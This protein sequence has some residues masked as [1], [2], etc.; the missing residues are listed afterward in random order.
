MTE[1]PLVIY[2]PENSKIGKHT[3]NFDK[4][5]LYLNYRINS[6]GIT[7]E[8][9]P[10][11]KKKMIDYNKLIS[12]YEAETKCKVGSCPTQKKK[13]NLKAKLLS[14]EKPNQNT[15]IRDALKNLTI[16]EVYNFSETPLT[17]FEKVEK[18]PV[19]QLF[20]KNMQNQ[21]MPKENLYKFMNLDNICR[22]DSLED[23]RVFSFNVE[24]LVKER[25]TEEKHLMKKC[26]SH[27]I[28]NTQNCPRNAKNLRISKSSAVV[29]QIQ[30]KIE[31]LRK[32]NISLRRK[33]QLIR[34]I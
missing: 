15:K 25:A 32:E 29:L 9:S 18:K 4:Y 20:P 12:P 10:P 7:L 17:V 26:K 6:N 21:S 19:F 24:K 11:Q 28:S 30:N 23:T 27:I 31:K 33:L 34:K 14:K 1:R 3:L 16:Q 22:G 13:T 8:I 5:L 2:L